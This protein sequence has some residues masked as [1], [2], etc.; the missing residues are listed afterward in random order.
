M[1]IFFQQSY[2]CCLAE[3]FL[4]LYVEILR[5]CFFLLIMQDNKTYFFAREWLEK[6]IA[7]GGQ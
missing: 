4:T 2:H 6:Y 3:Q 1:F 5:T 7:D